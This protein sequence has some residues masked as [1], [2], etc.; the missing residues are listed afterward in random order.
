MLVLPLPEIR[1]T[2]EAKVS[3]P[4]SFYKALTREAISVIAEVKKAS[5]SRGLI[6]EDFNHL[7][8]AE[9][10]ERGGAA[11]LSVLTDNRFFQGDLRYLAEIAGQVN[12]P[13]LRKDFIIHEYQI[14]EAAVNGASSVLLIAAVLDRKRMSAFL[15]LCR[16]YGLDALVEVHNR[17]ELE[18]ALSCGAEIIGVNNRDLKSFKVDLKVSEEL[19]PYIPADKIQV[20]ESGIHCREHIHRLQQAG[21]NAFLVGES[22]MCRRD[23]VR[24]LQEL[25]G[26]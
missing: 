22:L 10:Y 13:L 24:A 25:R 11:A 4:L 12:L 9:E 6:C 16:E 8:I 20:T 18:N 5:P 15:T 23:R 3:R 19:A 2:V 17:K 21:F 26:I 7:H 14:Y 1:R